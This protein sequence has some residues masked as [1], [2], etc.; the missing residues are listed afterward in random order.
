KA[1]NLLQRDRVF[2]DKI[3]K[4]WQMSGLT[5][6]EAPEIDLSPQ[7]IADSQLQMMFAICH[8]SIPVEAQIGLSL[9]ILCGFGIE[10]IADAFL[11]SKDTINKRLYRAKEKIREE[12]I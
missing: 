12:K 5:S 10:E 2:R 3:V 8:P 7:N 6:V 9:R 4:E 11:V 1:K